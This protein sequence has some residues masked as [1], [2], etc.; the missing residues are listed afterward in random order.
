MNC[1]YFLGSY[2]KR[3]VIWLCAALVVFLAV[4]SFS[5]ERFRH[6]LPCAV[7]SEDDSPEARSVTDYLLETGFVKADS[8]QGL[9]EMIRTGKA[10]TG[11]ILVREFSEYLEEG[12]MSRSA[13]FVISES[14][15]RVHINKLMAAVAI[16]QAVQPYL[17]SGAANDFGYQASA[18][19]ILQYEKEVE[20][21]A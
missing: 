17:T 7:Y 21:R 8:V 9:I 10:D 5:T 14:S 16:Y 18:E 2:L 13:V 1:F 6:S 11:V 20:E 19:D 3:P 12:N 4:F 15:M